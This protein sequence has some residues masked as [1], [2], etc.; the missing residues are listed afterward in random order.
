MLPKEIQLSKKSKVKSKN[1]KAKV[2][3]K[4]GFEF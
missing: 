3:T 4:D 1:Q 2:K